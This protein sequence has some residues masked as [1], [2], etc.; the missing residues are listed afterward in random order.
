MKLLLCTHAGRAETNMTTS[1][2]HHHHHASAQ[3]GSTDGV[4]DVHTCRHDTAVPSDLPPPLSLPATLDVGAYI[5]VALAALYQETGP[6]E[7]MIDVYAHS[8]VTQPSPATRPP[9]AS[10]S[11]LLSFETLW[12]MYA[13]KGSVGPPYTYSY[14]QEYRSLWATQRADLHRLVTMKATRSHY[15]TMASTMKD[16]L[17]NLLH[18]A[19]LA[20]MDVDLDCSHTCIRSRQSCFP[21][22][23]LP[24]CSVV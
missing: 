5:F 12:S 13:Q 6:H 18:S 23:C 24:Y 1:E 17:L 20:G 9:M 21:F 16:G 3:I 19:E 4:C 2:A 22:V 11:D 8:F 10:S 7:H 14:M 15:I